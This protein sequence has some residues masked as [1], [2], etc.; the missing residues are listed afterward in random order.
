MKAFDYKKIDFEPNEFIRSLLI[1]RCKSHGNSELSFYAAKQFTKSSNQKT[2]SSTAYHSEKL[3]IAF[4]L[5]NTP[6][7]AQSWPSS[8]FASLN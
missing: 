6:N 4:A 5:L 8:D 1:A 3:A 7:A 2:H